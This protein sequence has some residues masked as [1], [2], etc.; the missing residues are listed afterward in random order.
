MMQSVSDLSL[1]FFPD[2]RRCRQRRTLQ[3]CAAAST[4]RFILG[5]LPTTSG[6][7]FWF[8][9]SNEKFPQGSS[10]HPEGL[11]GTQ[12]VFSAAVPLMTTRAS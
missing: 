3:T 8:A 4:L 5:E 10:E 7:I 6:S 2:V 11:R 12:V 9:V 1:N